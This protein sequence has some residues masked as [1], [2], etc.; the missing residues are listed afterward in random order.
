ML[1]Y[2]KIVYRQYNILL[3]DNYH[4]KISDSFFPSPQT[5]KRALSIYGWFGYPPKGA[6][7]GLAGSKDS[8]FKELE[9]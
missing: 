5:E 1:K 2:L 8:S 3:E 7:K 4:S 6:R 9:L